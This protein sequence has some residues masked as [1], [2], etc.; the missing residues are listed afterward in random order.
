M[1]RLLRHLIFVAGIL[2]M[3]CPL[4]FATAS[5]TST[6][7]WLRD[8][9]LAFHQAKAE[10]RFVLLYLEAVWCHW[11]HVMDHDTYSDPQIATQIAA[12]YVPLR[13]DQDARP[14]LANRY[15]DYGWPAT[16]VFSADGEEIVKRQGYQPPE[17]FLRLLRAIVED[18][19]P[20]AVSTATT[21]QTDNSAQKGQLEDSLRA[22]LAARHRDTDDEK[23]GGLQ[24]THKFLDRDT[25]EYA[26]TR[27]EAGDAGEKALAQRTLD[28]AW[29]LF[30][31]AWGGVYQYSTNADWQHVHYEK[32]ATVQAEYLR[33]YALAWASFHRDTDR[34]AVA[35]IRRYL[36]TFLHAPDGGYY[37]SQDAD[38]K[39]GEHSDAFFSLDDAGRRALG[40]PR[41]DKHV[42]AQQTAAMAEALATW[43]E[44]SG[45]ASALDQA[46]DAL[47]WVQKERALPEG[48]GGY[49]HDQHD[50]AGPYLAD[51]LAVGRA[52]LAL[53]RA[54]AD[55]HW[56]QV[57]IDAA[58]FIQAH[59]RHAGGGYDGAASQGPIAAALQV[60]E[61]ISLAR[62]TNLL[63]HYSGQTVHR[64][65]AEHAMRWLAQPDVGLARIT[66]AG[67]LL[68]DAELGVD[69]R[70]LVTVGA[71]AAAASKNLFSTLQQL[72]GW[73]KRVEWWDRSEG[74]LPYPDVEYPRLKRSAAFVCTHNRCS[75]P[76]F[77]TG[78]ITD[79]LAQSAGN[80]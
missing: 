45:D 40:L 29:A 59:F 48:K 79:F 70:H 52:A 14:D 63:S 51:T 53:Y 54:D 56:L 5:T 1:N 60:D 80:G 2:L 20:E 76:L 11:C 73:Y 39:P 37:V 18:P 72:P 17:R 41:V 58:N 65:M 26:L 47:R 75:L 24:L 62:Y 27:A 31:P 66:E 9:T 68:A 71:K 69:P 23:L 46:R 50:S 16:I 21:Q 74:V 7:T 3:A 49:R 42:Y 25:V 61:N 57:S 55:R 35:S 67:V 30:D 22:K 12:H 77:D 28:A 13:I 10:H 33:I 4:V 8:E 6:L 19:S 34:Q 44:V 36:D 32:L 78:Q 64:E 15:R 43:A 38:L